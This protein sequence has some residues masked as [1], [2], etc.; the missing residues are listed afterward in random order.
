MNY[1]SKCCPVDKDVYCHIN[2]YA[3]LG[4]NMIQAVL[5]QAMLVFFY[6]RLLSNL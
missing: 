4:S 3:R 5:L 6:Q 2:Q 1:S